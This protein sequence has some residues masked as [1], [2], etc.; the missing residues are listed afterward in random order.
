MPRFLF[1]VLSLAA[2][3]AVA[4]TVDMFAGMPG[5][6]IADYDV[7][8]DDAAAIRAQIEAK[9]PVDPN[10]PA[11]SFGGAT[12]FAIRWRWPIDRA[13]RCDLTAARVTFAATVT[14]PRL[15]GDV[16]DTLR[17]DWDRYR[18]ALERHEAEHVRYAY[19]RR[20]DIA[21]AIRRARC[22]TADAAATRVLAD[23]VAHERAIDRTTRHGASDD[24]VFP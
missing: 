18:A 4:Q 1:Y 14:L 5:V 11:R 13:G 22:A 17:N 6:T 15:T 3:P 16:P 12:T 23:I 7:A 2:V 19:D 10:D 20:G 9:G 8:G 21:R 24:I